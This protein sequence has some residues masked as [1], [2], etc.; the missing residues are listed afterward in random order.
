MKKLFRFVL[1]ILAALALVNC[2]PEATDEQA[3]AAVTIDPASLAQCGP[4][5]YCRLTTGGSAYWH[6]ATPANLAACTSFC[7][8]HGNPVTCYYTRAAC[9]GTCTC[10]K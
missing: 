5:Y 7:S 4:G 8:T 2:G 1:P 9:D 6:G 3:T 10:P